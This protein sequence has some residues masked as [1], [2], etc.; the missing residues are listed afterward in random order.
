MCKIW[1]LERG[2]VYPKSV[3][4]WKCDQA[5]DPPKPWFRFRPKPVSFGFGRTQVETETETETTISNK[6]ARFWVFLENSDQYFSSYLLFFLK[7]C[8]ICVIRSDTITF[9]A[10]VCKQNLLWRGI[11]ANCSIEFR[12]RFRYRFRPKLGGFG[13]GFGRN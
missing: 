11:I 3:N 5:S 9:R 12:F 7:N 2:N 6:I 8:F 13:F 10:H 4:L 1:I